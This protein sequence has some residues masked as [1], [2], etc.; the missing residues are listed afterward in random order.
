MRMHSG[1]SGNA[2]DLSCPYATNRWW[3]YIQGSHRTSNWRRILISWWVEAVWGIP[4]IR[5]I[6]TRIPADIAWN[7]R[8]SHPV[9]Y[10]HPV[11]ET[12]RVIFFI[13]LFSSAIYET[14]NQ[15]KFSWLMFF[16]ITKCCGIAAHG[17]KRK[18]H[19]LP[20]IPFYHG[21][22]S[23]FLH[24]FHGD[25]SARPGMSLSRTLAGHHTVLDGRRRH[26]M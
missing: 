25:D 15:K 9:E 14:A 21:Y 4:T 8:K 10:H 23:C 6:R 1:S 13:E 5:A 16:I 24:V 7:N 19:T 26:R 18:I 17:I 12:S 20:R 3:V 22:L 2:G 11:R